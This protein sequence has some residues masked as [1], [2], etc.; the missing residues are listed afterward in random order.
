[1]TLDNDKNNAS[2][3]FDPVLGPPVAK[4]WLWA[5]TV[6]MLLIV[7]GTVIPV[8]RLDTM[9][10]KY[11]YT[12]GAVL[13]LVSR[14]F[15]PYRG[16]NDRLRRLFRIESWSAVFFCVAAF[17]M[18]Y[19]PNTAR[20]WLAFTLAGGAIQIYTS[21]MIPRTASKARKQK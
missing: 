5:M 10:Y 9:A 20:D 12:A 21:I 8:F 15:T 18:F 14:L 13:L 2:R 19:E 3:D 7:A 16:D 1:M 11:V 4:V 6:G 17:F